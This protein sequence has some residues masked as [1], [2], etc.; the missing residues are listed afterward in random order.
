MSSAASKQRIL[1]AGFGSVLHGDDAFGVEVAQRLQAR[2][3]WS[4]GVDIVEV[5]A[6]GIHMVQRLCDGYQGL[7]V[8]DTVRRVGPPGT[9]HLLRVRVPALE[10]WSEEERRAFLADMHYAEPSRALV[11]AQALHVLPREAFILG[12][13]P[14]TVDDVRLGLSPAVEQ[15]VEAAVIEVERLLRVWQQPGSSQSAGP[16]PDQI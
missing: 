15:A 4:A 13:I 6:G 10:S 11:L 3:P 5:G 1:I 9:L 14:Q 7:L 12:C 8:L 2:G 16:L